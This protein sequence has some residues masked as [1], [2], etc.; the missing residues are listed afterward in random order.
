MDFKLFGPGG[1]PN[2]HFQKGLK[3]L[4]DLDDEAWKWVMTR[5]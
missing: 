3:I 5:K 4:F 2:N 1:S